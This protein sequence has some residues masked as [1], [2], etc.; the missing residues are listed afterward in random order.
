MKVFQWSPFTCLI[1]QQN[2]WTVCR[3]IQTGWQHSF[4]HL[5]PQQEHLKSYEPM[6]IISNYYCYFLSCSDI[7]MRISRKNLC[8]SYCRKGVMYHINR[9]KPCFY[10]IPKRFG[11]WRSVNPTS[12]YNSLKQ[13]HC[14]PEAHCNC[15][16]TEKD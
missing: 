4:Y 12:V 1:Y 5:A 3:T 13:L 14:F 6:L 7:Q 9:T 10:M 16:I 15:R 8:N 2:L 11:A